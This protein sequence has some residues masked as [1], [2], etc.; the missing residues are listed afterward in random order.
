[1]GAELVIHVRRPGHIRV[2]TRRADRDVEGK[3]G[4]AP[5]VVVVTSMVLL[6]LARGARDGG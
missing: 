6:G 3:A 4:M 1:V 2:S 5:Q